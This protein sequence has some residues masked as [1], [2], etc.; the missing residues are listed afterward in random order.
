VHGRPPEIDPGLLFSLGRG[1]FHWRRS[2]AAEASLTQA[3]SS[4]PYIG[5]ADVGIS[6]P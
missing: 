4:V 2:S 6:A 3:G 5:A 1:A